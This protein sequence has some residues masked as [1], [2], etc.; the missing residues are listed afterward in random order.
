MCLRRFSPSR[1]AARRTTRQ[2]RIHQ[3]RHR[4][5]QRRPIR[6]R[7]SD[8]VPSGPRGQP[9]GQCGLVHDCRSLVPHTAPNDVRLGSVER[10]R[11]S[12]E[13]PAACGHVRRARR[14]SDRDGGAR[15]D[16]SARRQARDHDAGEVRRPWSG[17]SS[18]A[19]KG[20]AVLGAQQRRSS[21]DSSARSE[22]RVAKKL[23][24]LELVSRSIRR[25]A[26]RRPTHPSTSRRSWR[27]RAWWATSTR[28]RF[29]G[30]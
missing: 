20:S 8:E 24:R 9:H 18:D 16:V 19:R 27:S 7:R 28:R 14:Q 3:L 22:Q 21:V 6:I 4:K 5:P 12:R 29:P 23:R 10:H 30:S 25:I 11:L 17:R 13:R 2:H 15:R 1:P 26:S